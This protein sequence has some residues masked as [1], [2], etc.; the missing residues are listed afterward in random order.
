[1]A[2]LE[3][4]RDTGRDLSRLGIL[5]FL[6]VAVAGIFYVKWDPY[7]AK[8]LHAAAAHTLGP[9]IVTGTSAAAPPFSIGA[10]LDYGIAYFQ[11]IWQAL[12]VALLLGAGVQ[13][14][15][16]DGWLAKVLGR[17]DVRS[18]AIAG[19]AAVPSM[20]CTCCAAPLAVGL[21]RANAS[22]GAVLAYWVAN[23]VLNP[24]TIIFLGF[25]LG[26][27]WALLRVAVGVPLVATLAWY[28]NRYV[29]HA[30]LALQSVP[31]SVVRRPGENLITAWLKATLRLA[32]GLVPEYLVI[33]LVL[34]AVRS[35]LFPAMSPVIGGSILLLL[36]LTVAGTLFVVP[37]AGEV[38]ILQTLF[39]YGLGSA[40][41][42][43]L[44]LTLPAVS[45]PSLWM[46]GKAL[47]RK[48]L[49]VVAAI[50]AGF[51]VITGLLAMLFGLH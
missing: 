38:P 4:E 17:A 34:G 39:S 8:A 7:F 2:L 12:A 24:A 47:P 11:D 48:N 5:L 33:V 49:A 29:P 20:M 18:S 43:A 32:L 50:V 51:G 15:L 41:G 45:L 30:D 6:V 40:G 37:T 21:R 3:T 46:V 36:L 23:P 44:M 42:G 28:G 31:P 16:P 35:L 14:L 9:S 10:A 19:V 13:T 22:P 25:V 27:G 26:W 1:M